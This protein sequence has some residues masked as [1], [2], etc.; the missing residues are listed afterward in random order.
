MNNSRLVTATALLVLAG[1]IP[2]YV[3]STR[4]DAATLALVPETPSYIHVSGFANGKECRTQLSL[5]KGFLRQRTDVRVPPGEEFTVLASL[6]DPAFNCSVA[7][8]FMPKARESYTALINGTPEKCSMRIIRSD[9]TTPEPSMRRRTW[10]QP[11]WSSDEAQCHEA[12][13]SPRKHT[14]PSRF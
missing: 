1:C 4:D 13:P 6:A 5:A 8:S 14:T 7:V 10:T 3:S 2:A 12:E 9:G 11:T